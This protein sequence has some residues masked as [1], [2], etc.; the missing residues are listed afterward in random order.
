[1]NRIHSFVPMRCLAVAMTVA[2][3][4]AAAAVV[5]TKLIRQLQNAFSNYL[6]NIKC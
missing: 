1:M 3:A 2:A 4:A 5:A 6:T